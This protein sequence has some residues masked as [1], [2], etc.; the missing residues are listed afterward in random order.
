MNSRRL[1]AIAR[2]ILGLAIGLAIAWYLTKNIGPSP[3]VW[4][5]L[6]R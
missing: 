5:G 4:G 1:S 6:V 2:G 3:E